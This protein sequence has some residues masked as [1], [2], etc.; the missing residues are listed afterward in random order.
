MFRKSMFVALAMGAVGV[1]PMPALALTGAVP[2]SVDTNVALV[3]F[4]FPDGT[5]G[6]CSGTLI[7]PDV[8]LTAGHCAVG[9]SNVRVSFDF[10]TPGDPEEANISDAEKADRLQ[11]YIS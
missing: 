6:I 3:R 11:H 2:D 5:L 10:L 1:A 7:A 8:V 9:V 4:I